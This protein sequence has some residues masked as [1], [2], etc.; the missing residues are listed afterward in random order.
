MKAVLF[1]K[2]RFGLLAVAL[3]GAAQAAWPSP[4]MA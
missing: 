2:I 4:R 3:T 1:R